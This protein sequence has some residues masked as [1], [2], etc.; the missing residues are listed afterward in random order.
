[1]SAEGA[2]LR[3][4]HIHVVKR[5]VSVETPTSPAR[6]EEIVSCG[7]LHAAVFLTVQ[8][9]CITAPLWRPLMMSVFQ[10]FNI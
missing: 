10:C 6:H 8:C 1:M 7:R 4:N 5:F 2:A 9:H 3:L